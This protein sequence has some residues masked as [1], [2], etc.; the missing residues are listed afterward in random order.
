MK[1]LRYSVLRRKRAALRKQ[2]PDPERILRGSLV[3]RYKRC[4]NP[5]CHCVHDKGHGPAL[6]LS[7]TL[8]PGRTR[9][10]YVPAALAGRVDRYLRNYRELRKL[11]EKITS[12]NRELLTYGEEG[13]D[14]EPPRDRG[15][16]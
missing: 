9:S 10:Y 2:L 8:G 6:Y 16:T 15:S 5:G 14:A 13:L 11:L 3:K 1:N 4:G 12:I 7:V